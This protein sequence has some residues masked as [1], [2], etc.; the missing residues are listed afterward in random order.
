VTALV[1]RQGVV[2]GR[3]SFGDAV[4]E[5]ERRPIGTDT[6]FAVASVTKPFTATAIMQLVE[7][8]T[9]SIDQPVRELI[10]EFAGPGKENI[11]LRH[12]LTHTSGLPEYAED[13]EEIRRHRRGLDA[14]VRSYC[15]G[16]L[17]FPPG[18]QWSYSNFGFGLAGEI[19]ARYGGQGYHE[20]VTD[21][22]LAPLGMRDSYLQPAES[23]W[24][25]IAWVWLPGEPPTAHE[26]YNSPYF[27]RLGIP[28]G[29]LYATPEDLAVF[30]QTFLQG[31]VYEGRRILGA[32]AVREMTRNQLSE[33][34]RDTSGVA[35]WRT[36]SWGIGWDVKGNKAPHHSGAL[37][38]PATFGHTGS[39]GSML[40]AD[41][42]L[43]LVC[44][45][46]GTRLAESGWVD[47][48]L[49]R[50]ALFSN[51]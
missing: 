15:R 45:M 48:P 40:W 12:F 31:G 43:D 35:R 4:R 26:R 10:P 22:I 13:D 38:S 6:L 32:T 44:V 2:V 33:S 16:R 14:F 46:I 27:R 9:L 47:G 51:A 28:W 17:L 5:P 25:R 1:A 49:P 21:R 11:T 20:F 29:G 42:A 3:F 39:S 30:A 41:P 24:D 7:R 19:V 18:S 36:A 8:G 23:A 34:I 50:R 37:T